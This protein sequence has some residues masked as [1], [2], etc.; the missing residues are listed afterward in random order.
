MSEWKLRYQQ[1]HMLRATSAIAL[2]TGVVAA[3]QALAQTASDSATTT[4]QTTGAQLAPDSRGDALNEVVVSATRTARAVDHIPGAVGVI[5]SQDLSNI[6][7]ST[8]DP[9]EALAQMIPG[10]TASSDDLTSNGEL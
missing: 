8:L 7:R 4:L 9:D 1:S 10:F 2:L 3:P 6:Q 5:S